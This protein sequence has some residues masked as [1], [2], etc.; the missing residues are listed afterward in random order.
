M[1]DKIFLKDSNYEI[2]NYEEKDNKVYINIKSKVTKCKCPKCGIESNNYH[3]TYVRTIQDTPMHNIETWLRVFTYEFECNNINCE[4][5]TFTEELS[6]VRRHKV[7]TDALIQFIL[8]IS[9]FLSSTSASLILSFLGVKISADAIDD[10]IKNIKIVDNPD[11]EA[12]GI[13]D[14]A[15]RK[16]LTYATAIYDLKDHHLIALLEGRD[17]DTVKEWLKN[18]K[19]IKIVARDRA[20]AYAAAINEILPDCIQVADRFHLFENLIKYLKEIFYNEFPEKIFIKGNKIVKSNE[21]KKV[22]IEFE[23]DKEKLDKLN[24]D[25]SPPV[26]IYGNIIKFS[27]KK[28]NYYSKQNNKQEQKRKEKIELILNLK[29]RLQN[30]TCHETKTIAKEFGINVITLYRY[31]KMTIEEIYKVPT[32]KEYKKRKTVMD[33]YINIIYK[34]I[35][36]D[37]EPKYIVAYIQ[38]LGYKGEIFNIRDSII[39]ITKNNNLSYNYSSL[40]YLKYKYPDDVII[41]TRYEL[42]KYLLTIDEKKK[43]NTIAENIDIILEKYPIVKKIKEIFIDFHD[44]IFSND[45][46]MLDAFIATYENDIESFCNGLK[47]DI[48]PI[49]NAISLKI[50]SGFVEGNNNKFKLIKRIVYGKM[51]LVNLFKK[52]YLCFLATTDNFKIEDIVEAILT[53]SKK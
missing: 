14:V 48:A 41:I 17:A 18:H 9:I 31:K 33:D 15:I 40:I 5:K 21:I 32:R 4:I 28:H 50:N 53:D 10:I 27:S 1:I 51:N 47:K 34:M 26:D 11:V 8:S 2:T 22:P 7:K 52:S 45:V 12:I 49:K 6:F 35:I 20:N 13:D 30:A 3:S 38:K 39:A 25:N 16:G 19:K 29:N 36:D 44:T 23:I 24:Y 43:N 42:L 46:E 37:I